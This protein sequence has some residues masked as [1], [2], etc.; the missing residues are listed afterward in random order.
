MASGYD[1]RASALRRAKTPEARA[2]LRGK[3]DGIDLARRQAVIVIVTTT[4][5]FV[6]GHLMLMSV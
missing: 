3:H 6:V 2:Y 1:T 5:V 4:V